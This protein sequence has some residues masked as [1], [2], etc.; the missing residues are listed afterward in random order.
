MA[1]R[2]GGRGAGARSSPS[3]SPVQP[4]HGG[5]GASAVSVDRPFILRNPVVSGGSGGVV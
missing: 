2:G 1:S 3:G 5:P 4:R